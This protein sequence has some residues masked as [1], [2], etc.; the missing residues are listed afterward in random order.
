[1]KEF[2]TVPSNRFRV[3]NMT[4]D[5]VPDDELRRVRR[6][7]RKFG[8]S[9]FMTSQFAKRYRTKRYQTSGDEDWMKIVL[10]KEEDDFYT[11]DGER[12]YSFDFRTDKFEALVDCMNEL[13]NRTCLHFSTS[14]D[15]NMYSDVQMYAYGGV[16]EN[17]YIPY[18][19][20]DYNCPFDKD[21]DYYMVTSKYVKRS[22]IPG[23]ESDLVEIMDRLYRN[24]LLDIR[25]YGWKLTCRIAKPSRQQVET[26][27][28]TD[29]LVT[30]GKFEYRW[31]ED[32]G[33]GDFCVYLLQYRNGSIRYL[34]IGPG[35]KAAWT[36]H[37]EISDML[38][39]MVYRYVSGKLGMH[40]P[41]Y[42]RTL[43]AYKD[44]SNWTLCKYMDPSNV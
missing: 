31:T 25:K 16:L 30:C 28:P 12:D 4:R 36:S 1:M 39:T 13:D 24:C 40:R 42:F 34:L 3:E 18:L 5:S 17:M 6:I 27:M 32:T 37:D 38:G 44:P 43:C 29:G 8:V 15:S 20:A 2:D 11:E 14:G 21:H 23:R 10:F 35:N 41:E 33:T 22:E 7:C 9:V 26:F 19:F